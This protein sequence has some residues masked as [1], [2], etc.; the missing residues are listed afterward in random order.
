MWLWFGCTC[1]MGAHYCLGSQL[2]L[3]ELAAALAEL[4]RSYSLTVERYTEWKGEQIHVLPFLWLRVWHWCALLPGV[5]AGVGGAHCRACGA[6]AQLQPDS[7][8]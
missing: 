4:G 6:G 8:H 3:A 7:Q 5:I 1:G 2:A